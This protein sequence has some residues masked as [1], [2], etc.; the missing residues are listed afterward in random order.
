[1]KIEGK[2]FYL[3]QLLSIFEGR[4]RLHLY[5]K[6]IIEPETLVITAVTTYPFYFV[7]LTAKL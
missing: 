4:A 3:K 6:G 2:P 7:L 5:L 1:M